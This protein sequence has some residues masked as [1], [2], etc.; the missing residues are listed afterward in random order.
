MKEGNIPIAHVTKRQK[1]KVALLHTSSQYTKEGNI[2]VACV[3]IRQLQDEAL[4]HTNVL[5]SVHLGRRFPCGL[6]DYQVSLI[7]NLHTSIPYTKR[8]LVHTGNQYI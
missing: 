6:C 5:Q 2:H 3:T 7:E 1:Q 4:L 8:A